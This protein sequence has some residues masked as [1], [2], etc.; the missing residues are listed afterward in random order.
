M[1]DKIGLFAKKVEPFNAESKEKVNL[2]NYK[3][4]IAKIQSKVSQKT[5]VLKERPI[6]KDKEA[7]IADKKIECSGPSNFQSL[8]LSTDRLNT[9]NKNLIARMSNERGAKQQI[10]TTSRLKS[11]PSESTGRDRSTLKER[12]NRLS[13]LERKRKEATPKPDLLASKKI[14]GK[15]K[16]PI[17]GGLS[18]LQTFHIHQL[19]NQPKER[20]KSSKEGSSSNG[21]NSTQYGKK[22]D[23]NQKF[24]QGLEILKKRIAQLPGRSSHIVQS[25]VTGEDSSRNKLLSKKLETKQ[26]DSP[27]TKQGEAP[28]IDINLYKKKVDP[29]AYK[30]DEQSSLKMMKDRRSPNATDSKRNNGLN[31]T[32]KI[33]IK[34]RE[35]TIN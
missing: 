16:A 10:S 18:L 3:S 26:G 24:S 32:S 8:K 1:E 7:K 11:R 34:D 22:T 9:I 31:G 14:E 23:P 20:S 2:S 33:K 29:L 6:Q 25:E 12:I 17:Q 28:V 30:R 13:T 19:R 5:S 21:T 4:L 15:K 27:G 35:T